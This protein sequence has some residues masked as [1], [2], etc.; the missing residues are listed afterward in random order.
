LHLLLLLESHLL[1]L[2][3]Q[4]LPL[5]LQSFLLHL[6]QLHLLNPLLPAMLQVG[7]FEASSV[8]LIITLFVFYH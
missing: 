6:L 1:H 2:L 7:F 3:Q 5:L 4:H 8:L